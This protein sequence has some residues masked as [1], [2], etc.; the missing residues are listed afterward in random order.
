MVPPDCAYIARKSVSSVIDQP[1][2]L[3]PLARVIAKNSGRVRSED[4]AM[5]NTLVNELSAIG[6]PFI[7]FFMFGDETECLESAYSNNATIFKSKTWKSFAVDSRL[8]DFARCT[9]SADLVE[10]KPSHSNA[11]PRKR[12]SKLNDAKDANTDASP[13]LSKQKS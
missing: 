9:I 12:R 3:S 11:N 5:L 6:E 1:L 2:L 7:F 8:D 13:S 4:K 10:N